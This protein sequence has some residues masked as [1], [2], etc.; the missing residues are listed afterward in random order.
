MKKKVVLS[1]LIG[2]CL[3]LLIVLGIQLTPYINYKYATHLY[4]EKKYIDAS[5]VFFNLETYRDSKDMYNKS[6]LNLM[7]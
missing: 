2:V 4:N 3:I 5:E 6:Q 7:N 1:V